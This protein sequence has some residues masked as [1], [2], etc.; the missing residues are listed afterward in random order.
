MDSIDKKWIGYYENYIREKNKKPDDRNIIIKNIFHSNTIDNTA[1]TFYLRQFND[2]ITPDEKKPEQ[3]TNIENIRD[4]FKNSMKAIEIGKSD[5]EK[6]KIIKNIQQ[7]LLKNLNFINLKK[8][9]DYKN[10]KFNFLNIRR[11]IN[12]LEKYKIK[13]P[14][15]GDSSEDTNNLNTIL[16]QLYILYKTFIND[17]FINILETPKFYD[18]LKYEIF[19][20]VYLHPTADSYRFNLLKIIIDLFYLLTILKD[21]EESLIIGKLLLDVAF[22][23]GVSDKAPLTET[24]VSK[25][26]NLKLL[27]NIIIYILNKTKTHDD[28]KR[29]N[30]KLT[31]FDVFNESDPKKGYDNKKLLNLATLL[32]QIKTQSKSESGYKKPGSGSGTPGL[33]HKKPGSGSGTYHLAHRKSKLSHKNKSHKK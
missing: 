13:L 7:N 18:K 31:I 28:Y 2:N 5:D 17:D 24:I 12:N 21:N 30:G 11:D 14:I 32:L 1:I 29:L 8:F 27:C 26:N 23:S 9:M 33:G 10:S 25:L 3:K 6:D 22:Y 20:Y 16:E 4:Y 19:Y 15:V